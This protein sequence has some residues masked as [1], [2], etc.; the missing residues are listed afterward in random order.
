MD[1]AKIIA[2]KSIKAVIQEK[3]ILETLALDRSDL[4]SNIVASFQDREKAYILM[5]FISGKNLR[6]YLLE[7]LKLQ[8]EQISKLRF[9]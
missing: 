7:N 8:E 1:K 6:A 4:I 3:N 5:E 2:K 9:T